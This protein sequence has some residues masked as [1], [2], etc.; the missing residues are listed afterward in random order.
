MT[1]PS[2]GPGA[3]PSTALSSASSTTTC[4]AAAVGNYGHVP[5]GSCGSNYEYDPSFGGNVA[6]AVLFGLST[7]VHLVQ[8]IV[9]KKTFAWVLLMGGAWET[10]AFGIRTAGAHDQQQLQFVIWGQLLLLL[11]PLWI[12]AFAYMT[13]ARG[14]YLGLPGKKIWGI[15]ATRLTMIFVWL[16]V[17]CFI[18]QGVG[19]SVLSGDSAAGVKNIG[20]RV[21]TAGIGLQLGF[22]V[23]FTGMTVSFYWEMRRVTGCRVGRMGWLIW[24]MLLVLGMI[25][26]RIVFRLV[27]FGPGLN[28]YNPMLGKETWPFLLDAFPMLVA[29]VALNVMHPGYVLRGPDGDFPRLTRAEKKAIRRQK[30]EEKR[31]RKVAKRGK[32]AGKYMNTENIVL[33]DARRA[34]SESEWPIQERQRVELVESA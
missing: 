14:V 23:V 29:L 11:A 15:G 9:L 24:T 18:V 2:L 13:V 21:Y 34:N 7:A 16:D 26:T 25:V 17:V 33:E 22:V 4:T 6:F 32:S 19:G 10:A 31:Q 28:Q 8:A 30:R 20:M 5:P 27:E 12:N 3:G 1:A